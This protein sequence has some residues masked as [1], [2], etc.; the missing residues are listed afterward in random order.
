MYNWYVLMTEQIQK[1]VCCCLSHCNFGELWCVRFLLELKLKDVEQQFPLL[2]SC[3]YVEVQVSS[4]C[5]FFSCPRSGS[6]VL[7]ESGAGRYH[8]RLLW[9]K[10]NNVN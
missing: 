6:G 9:T 2:C 3:I 1:E 7:S 8:L 10:E 5:L 4:S